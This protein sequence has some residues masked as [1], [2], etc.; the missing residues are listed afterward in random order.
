VYGAEEKRKTRMTDYSAVLHRRLPI[1]AEISAGL[2]FRF[3]I[4]PVA[5][6]I[7]MKSLGMK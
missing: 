1:L 7:I 5:A 6:W 2:F 3:V 4:L